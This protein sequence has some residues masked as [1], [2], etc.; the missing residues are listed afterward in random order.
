MTDSETASAEY[1]IKP[2][3]ATPTFDP[4]AGTYSLP[5][6]VTLSCT[7]SDATIRYTTDGTTPTTS[8]TVYSSPIPVSSTITIKA[9]ASKTE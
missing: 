5:Q 1:T 3:I 6:S 2:K 7:T 8:S 9:K 4:D